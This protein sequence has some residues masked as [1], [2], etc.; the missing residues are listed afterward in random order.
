MEK[1]RQDFNEKLTRLKKRLNAGSNMG[2]FGGGE[3]VLNVA[4]LSNRDG[5][6]G[7]GGPQNFTTRGGAPAGDTY[8]S[9]DLS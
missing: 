1:E 5:L 7:G 8:I 9:Q 6:F 2:S 4:S 3:L